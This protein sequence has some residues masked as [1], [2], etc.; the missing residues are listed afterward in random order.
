MRVLRRVLGW[1]NQRRVLSSVPLSFEWN[2]DWSDDSLL[3]TPALK[4][5]VKFVNDKDDGAFW[6]VRH[7]AC[8][9]LLTVPGVLVNKCCC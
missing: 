4:A 5:E 2:G 1:A 9:E 8:Q 3:W 6:M 7:L